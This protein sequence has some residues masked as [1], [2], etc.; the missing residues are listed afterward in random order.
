M[1]EQTRLHALDAVRGFAVLAGVV[2]HVTMS[3]LTGFTA[4]PS[5]FADQSPDCG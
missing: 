1:T 2:L 5:L 4:W 3:Y